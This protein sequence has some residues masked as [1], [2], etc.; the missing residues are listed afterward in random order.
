MEV[1][2]DC[3]EILQLYFSLP[4]QLFLLHL[5]FYQEGLHEQHPRDREYGNDY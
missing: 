3:F 5:L 4:Q 2:R 1:L